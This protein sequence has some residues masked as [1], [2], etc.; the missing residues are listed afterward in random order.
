MSGRQEEVGARWALAAAKTA[1]SLSRSTCLTI[2]FNRHGSCGTLGRLRPGTH[3]LTLPQWAPQSK[4]ATSAPPSVPLA[5]RYPNSVQSTSKCFI[6][7]FEL[8]TPRLGSALGGC[9]ADPLGEIPRYFRW[10]FF[11]L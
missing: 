2:R 7:R 6:S 4:P 11:I 10:N 5:D 1:K 3:R 8:G 9:F